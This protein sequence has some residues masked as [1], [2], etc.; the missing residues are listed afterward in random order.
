MALSCESV[1][2]SVVEFDL[3][4]AGIHNS[5]V[6][7]VSTYEEGKLTLDDYLK[8]TE[9]YSERSFTREIFKKFMFAQTTPDKEMIES[10]CHLENKYT[11][12]MR[13]LMTKPGI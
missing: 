1:R 6:V 2:A 13:L 5:H 10:M 12:K 7:F 11:L 9:F 3:D 4:Y 8:R